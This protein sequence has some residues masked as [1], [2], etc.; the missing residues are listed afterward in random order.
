M[1][2]NASAAEGPYHAAA[3]NLVVLPSANSCYFARFFYSA[4]G[5]AA[6]PDS[7]PRPCP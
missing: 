3:K 7:Q 2:Y 1:S 6:N 5:D 4:E